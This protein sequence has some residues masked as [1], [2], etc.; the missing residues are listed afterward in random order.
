MLKLVI[1][2][3]KLSCLFTL[4]CIFQIFSMSIYFSYNRNSNEL[5]IEMG[6]PKET[7]FIFSHQSVLHS[8]CFGLQAISLIV[9]SEHRQGRETKEALQLF[10]FKSL[11]EEAITSSHMI[12]VRTEFS[13]KEHYG[14]AYSDRKKYCSLCCASTS[15]LQLVSEKSRA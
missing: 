9:Y 6:T 12:L 2:G 11:Q 4:L 10:A 1:W 5:V 7:S 14:F 13:D 8:V 15:P 3:W